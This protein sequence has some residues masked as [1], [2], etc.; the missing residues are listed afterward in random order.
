MANEVAKQQDRELDDF[1]GY[2]D[3]MEGGEDQS[4]SNRVIQGSKLKFTNEATWI[5]DFEE[6]MPADLKL[7]VAGIGRIVQRWGKD[8]SQPPVTRVLAAGEKYPDIK[9][10]NEAVPRSE[11][12]EGLNGLQGPYQAAHALYLINLE[13]MQRYTWITSTVGGAICIRDLV[14]R[15]NMMRQFKGEKVFA[16][17]TLSDIY[18]N[19]KFGGRQ[20]PHLIV[21]DWVLLDGSK[22]VPAPDEPKA[23]PPTDKSKASTSSTKVLDEVPKVKPPTAKEVVDDEI[24]Y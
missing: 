16:V 14:D 22:A 1:S 3:E 11:W 20:R 13:D 21:R 6:E 12:R 5:N 24:R 7:V 23:L 18:M 10:L 9:A 2:N 15:V 19:T 17:V 4:A 8:S